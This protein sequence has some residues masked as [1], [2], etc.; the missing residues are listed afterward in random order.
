M[1]SKLDQ[2]ISGKVV[3]APALAARIYGDKSAF[4]DCGFLGFQD[5]LWD[6]QGRHYYKNCYIQG[7][8]DFIFGSGQSYFENCLINVTLT[9]SKARVRHGYITA[10]GRS[11]KDETSG[12]VFRGGKVV[13]SGP[14]FLG[15]AYGPYSRVIFHGTFLDSVISPQGWD[16]WHHTKNVGHLMYAEVDCIGQGAN[17]KKRVPWETNLSPAQL[18]QFSKSSFIDQDHWLAKIPL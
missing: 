8:M 15:R 1:E 5:T 6:V 13:G 12:F 2:T 18:N 11:S 17:R 7:A 4:F 16:D 14:V 9:T 10:Q 3:R